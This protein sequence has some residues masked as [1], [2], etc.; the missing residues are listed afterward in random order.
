[1]L[2][3]FLLALVGFALAGFMVN[4]LYV[5]LTNRQ[6]NVKGRVYSRASQ[7]I[8]YWITM[9]NATIGLILGIGIGLAGIVL[10]FGR[11]N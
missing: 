9:A 7:P 5:G 11:G 2:G 6:L 4:R 10:L 8:A 1:L 3:G